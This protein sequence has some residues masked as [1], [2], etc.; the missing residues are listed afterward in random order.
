MQ[1]WVRNR[2]RVEALD[3]IQISDEEKKELR[4]KHDDQS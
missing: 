1:L 4:K 2:Q 3:H